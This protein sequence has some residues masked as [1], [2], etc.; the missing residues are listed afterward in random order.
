M[1]KTK[2]GDCIDLGA[3]GGL[4]EVGARVTTSVR[5]ARLYVCGPEGVWGGRSLAD[6]DVVGCFLVVYI[7][8]L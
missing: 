5:R 4:G 1:T 2:E 3:T 7:L 8:I 6:R